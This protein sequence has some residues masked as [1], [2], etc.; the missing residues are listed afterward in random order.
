MCFSFEASAL[1]FL[2][3]WG[4]C[5][6]LLNKK[7]TQY[8]KH[9]VIF[10]LIFST[11]QLCDSI[12]WYIKN[13]KNMINYIVNSFFIP[14]ILSMQII[15]NIYF[16][17]K[18]NNPFLNIFIVITIIYIFKKF[19]GYSKSVC[20]FKKLSSPVWG[21]NELKFWELFI[22]SLLILLPRWDIIAFFNVI[23][24]PFIIYFFKGGYGSL[25]CAVANVFAIYYLFNY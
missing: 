19:N 4:T 22:F 10:L 6:Y 16:Y 1:T 25:W 17:N 8:Q 2:F 24:F 7:L 12:L 14:L 23:F 15:Y 20:C 21:S 13:K 9:N 11:I 18:I 5:F 3:S